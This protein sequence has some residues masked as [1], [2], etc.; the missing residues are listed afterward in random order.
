MLLNFEIEMAKIVMSKISSPSG[1]LAEIE[2]TS[3]FITSQL[4]ISSLLSG[5]MINLLIEL[6]PISV[7]RVYRHFE[8]VSGF[9]SYHVARSLI[10]KEDKIQVHVVKIADEDELVQRALFELVT[11]NLLHWNEAVDA[12]EIIYRQ[13][14]A[15]IVVLRNK[16]D[17]KVPEEFLGRNFKILFGLDGRKIKIRRQ[18]KTELQRILSYD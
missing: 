3:I 6:Y 15:L 16:Y 8:V 13:L 4:S 9:R 10:N 18:R 1:A 7:K 5:S 17:F 2:K 14:K 12:R 11:Q